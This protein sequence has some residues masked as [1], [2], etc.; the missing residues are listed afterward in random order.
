VQVDRQATWGR[1]VWLGPDDTFPPTAPHEREATRTLEMLV[2]ADPGLASHWTAGRSLSVA[3]AVAEAL[4][5][6]LLTSADMSDGSV[7]LT[8]IQAYRL[9]P[10]EQEILGL[11]C[12]RWTDPE[13]AER[14]FITRRT[15]S[16]HVAN[17]FAKLGVSS[18]RAAAALAVREGLV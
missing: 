6:D 17:L 13:I 9:S 11:L 18:R 12:E 4:A 14:L 3:A 16:T 8:R 1:G 5:I 10:R 2:L 15:A 7:P